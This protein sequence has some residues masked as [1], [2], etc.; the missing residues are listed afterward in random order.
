MEIKKSFRL[1]GWAY[2]Q[3][4][5][6][7]DDHVSGEMVPFDRGDEFMIYRVYDVLMKVDYSGN[8][9][10][11]TDQDTVDFHFSSDDERVY[12]PAFNLIWQTFCGRPDCLQKSNCSLTEIVYGED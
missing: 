12:T 8:P 6:A 3:V 2:D 7:V 5:D 1:K 9:R 11:G 4:M 10:E